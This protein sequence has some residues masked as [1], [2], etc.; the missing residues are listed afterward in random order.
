MESC[1]RISMGNT[2]VQQTGNKECPNI[3]FWN[4][5]VLELVELILRPPKGG[6][7]SLPEHGDAVS[8]LVA[9]YFISSECIFFSH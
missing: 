7:P 2:E 1:K 6:P 4:A 5:T 9:F 3:F 8:I